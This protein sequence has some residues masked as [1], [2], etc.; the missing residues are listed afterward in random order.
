MNRRTLLLTATFCIA[1]LFAAVVPR[2]APDFTVNL[3]GSGQLPLAKY[4]GK[5]V[6]L[7]FISPT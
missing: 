4:K 5:V 2:P 1:P 3:P 6:V 7:V